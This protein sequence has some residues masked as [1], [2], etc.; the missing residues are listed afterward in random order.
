MPRPPAASVRVKPKAGA[1]EGEGIKNSQIN[2]T[3]PRAIATAG[4]PGVASLW[5][6]DA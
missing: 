3:P 1:G 6:H 2:A 5:K 4:L